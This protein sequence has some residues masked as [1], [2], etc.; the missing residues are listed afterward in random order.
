M[1][2]ALELNPVAGTAPLFPAPGYAAPHFRRRV[3]ESPTPDSHDVVNSLRSWSRHHARKLLEKAERLAG[4]EPLKGGDFHPYR[5]A[6]ATSRKHLPLA[7]V[8]QAGGWKSTETLLRCYQRPDAETM[9]A[10]VAE[11][12][13]VRSISGKL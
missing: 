6:W 2:A 9:Y 3:P 10:V 8:A 11:Q 1:L 12:R 5:R 7:D 4:L 13:K